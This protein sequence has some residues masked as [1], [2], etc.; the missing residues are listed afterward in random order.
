VRK[1]RVPPTQSWEQIRTTPRPRRTRAQPPVVRKRPAR[2]HAPGFSQPPSSCQGES[3]HPAHPKFIVHPPASP[4]KP[5]IKMSDA[6][7]APVT[8]NGVPQ[9]TQDKI[10]EEVPGHKVCTPSN[11]SLRPPGSRSQVFVGNLAYSTTDE[12]LKAF[13]EPVQSDM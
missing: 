7:P 12:G 1:L 9:A 2:W 5:H 4:S 8:E 3:V 11:R 13:F 10:V 6:P